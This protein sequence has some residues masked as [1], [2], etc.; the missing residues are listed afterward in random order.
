MTRHLL[1]RRHA[2][3]RGFEWREVEG[4]AEYCDRVTS[5]VVP[6]LIFY[7]ITG[8]GYRFFYIYFG[9]FSHTFL[10][11]RRRI[12]KR[13]RPPDAA[14]GNSPYFLTCTT[15]RRVRFFGRSKVIGPCCFAVQHS[16]LPRRRESRRITRVT[17]I[18]VSDRRRAPSGGDREVPYRRNVSRAFVHARV[19]SGFF[20]FLLGIRRKHFLITLPDRR[21]TRKTSGGSRRTTICAASAATHTRVC[22]DGGPAGGRIAGVMK[23][24]HVAAVSAGRPSVPRTRGLCRRVQRQN[25]R[26]KHTRSRRRAS[27]LLF[28]NRRR[29]RRSSYTYLHI[30]VARVRGKIARYTY[31]YV[32]TPAG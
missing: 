31:V 22:F 28:R 16:S 13:S 17:N 32:C 8:Y 23:W 5:C 1:C 10:L 30:L 7:V 12:E 26:R 29:R 14:A 20:F 24:R 18:R 25:R 4:L 9:S 11:L 15:G 3:T 6:Y 19:E 27:S 21:R 2:S